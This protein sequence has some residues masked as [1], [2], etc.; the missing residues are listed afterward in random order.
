MIFRISFA[1][2]KGLRR[3]V[4]AA[5]LGDSQS[6]G[7]AFGVG[8]DICTIPPNVFDSMANHVLTDRGLAQFQLD[9]ES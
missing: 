6:V 3:K 1:D 4:L 7:V 2:V 5:S 9:F 8:A